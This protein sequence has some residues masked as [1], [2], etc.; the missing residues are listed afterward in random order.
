MA[1]QIMQPINR[2]IFNST[3]LDLSQTV[4][5]IEIV[6]TTLDLQQRFTVDIFSNNVCDKEEIKHVHQRR[7]ENQEHVAKLII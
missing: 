4:G 3:V 2:M 1:L 6:S 7:K 5:D